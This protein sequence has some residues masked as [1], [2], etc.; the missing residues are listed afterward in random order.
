MLG[1]SLSVSLFDEERLVS[2]SFVASIAR[3]QSNPS[4]SNLE[5]ALSVW[6]FSL[7]DS[8][9]HNACRLDSYCTRFFV[10]AANSSAVALSFHAWLERGVSD[11]NS[12]RVDL[13]SSSDWMAWI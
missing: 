5:R 13:N 1:P 7:G 12:S 4:K 3:C 9:A 11:L 8:L 2:G 10:Y 6:F